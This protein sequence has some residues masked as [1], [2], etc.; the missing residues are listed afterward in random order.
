MS[1][2]DLHLIDIQ[3]KADVHYATALAGYSAG[4]YEMG[5]RRIRK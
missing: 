1:L 3:R 5:E 4:V 2:L